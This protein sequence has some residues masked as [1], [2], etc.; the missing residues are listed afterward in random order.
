MAGLKS[1]L[2]TS[3]V[4]GRTGK[5]NATTQQGNPSLEPL[6]T[7]LTKG[8]KAAAEDQAYQ[9]KGAVPLT[10]AEIKQ[11]LQYLQ[12]Q[13]ANSSG[14]NKQLYLRDGLAISTLWQTTTRGFNA[15][16]IRLAN[17]RLLTG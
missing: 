14:I 15:G 1:H 13:Q 4:L 7:R 12:A 16:G 5:W 11:L 3:E 17:I 8:Y 9:Q 10:E 2:S 6:I